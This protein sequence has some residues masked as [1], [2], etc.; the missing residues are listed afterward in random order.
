MCQFPEFCCLFRRQVELAA[1]VHRIWRAWRAWRSSIT[2]HVDDLIQAEPAGSLPVSE[3]DH[4]C[5]VF[6][7]ENRALR[8]GPIGNARRQ[9]NELNEISH[10]ALEQ[11]H[12]PGM[13]I[14][15]GDRVGGQL[16]A[17]VSRGLFRCRNT[18]RNM[19][20]SRNV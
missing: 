13:T 18:T 11:A 2:L 20:H 15:D 3:L 12:Q 19:T 5:Q 8:S 17:F 1:K 16:D 14:Q 6:E 7:I 9:S 4:T 10:R